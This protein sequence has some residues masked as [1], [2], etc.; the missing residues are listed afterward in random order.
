MAKEFPECVSYNRFVELQKKV[1]QPLGVFM[2]MHCLGDCTGI[3]FIDSTTLKSCHYKREKQHK[4][5]VGLAQKSFGTLGWFCG[6][7]LHLVC[8]D[9]GEIIDFMLTP[10]NVDDRKPLKNKSL[11]QRRNFSRAFYIILLTSVLMT[12]SV[13]ARMIFPIIN[14]NNIVFGIMVGLIVSTSLALYHFLLRTSRNESALDV[15]QKVIEGSRGAR[16]IIDPVGNTLYANQNFDD[17]CHGVGAP[18]FTTL[19]KV[20]EDTPESEAHITKLMDDARRGLTDKLYLSTTIKGTPFTRL[21][22]LYP[23]EDG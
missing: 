10:G 14:E 1:V 20:F 21:G 4:V 3:S 12:G 2:K 9:K 17:F 13:C 23:L 16:L 8:N 7:K 19:L 5:F 22:R 6:F 11:L 15:L 18:S